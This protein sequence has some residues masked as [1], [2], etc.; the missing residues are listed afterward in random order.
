[1]SRARAWAGLDEGDGELEHAI[2]PG[3]DLSFGVDLPVVRRNADLR[4]K[5][6]LRSRREILQIVQVLMSTGRT[7]VCAEILQ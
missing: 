6:D 5:A 3:V 1:M 2:T 4:M 7:L